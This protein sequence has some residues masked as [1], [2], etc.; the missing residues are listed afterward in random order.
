MLTV[1]KSQSYSREAITLNEVRIFNLNMI[2]K[3]PNK[4]QLYFWIGYLRYF[5]QGLQADALEDFENFEKL[6]DK[7]MI[8]LKKESSKH[9]K[10]IKKEQK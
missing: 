2:A 9:I 10:S 8:T 5:K 3:Y 1:S 7:S 4:P 6:C